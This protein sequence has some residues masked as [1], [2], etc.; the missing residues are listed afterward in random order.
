MINQQ[1]QQKQ[2]CG[3]IVILGRPNVGKSTLLNRLVRQKLSIT[4]RKPQTTRDNIQGIDTEGNYQSIFIDTPG[5]FHRGQLS[6]HYNSEALRALKDVDT[7]LIVLSGLK[8]ESSDKK[9]IETALLAKKNNNQ[10]QLVIV[11]NKI[12][13][14]KD[15]K[16]LLAHIQC[17]FDSYSQFQ[18][19]TISA[20]N[21]KNIDNLRK[22][23]QSL[24]PK[25]A[26]I[27]RA[28]QITDATIKSISG[29]LVREKIVRQLGAELPYATTVIVE[30]FIEN[31]HNIA[32]NAVILVE[33]DSQ[34]AIVIG[35][36]GARLKSIGMAA[37]KDIT[38]MVD[39]KVVLKLW[40]K[41][42]PHWNKIDR[43]KHA[44]SRL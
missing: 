12:D 18:Y 10:L 26:F 27:Y 37:R 36:N 23:I 9:T 43:F 20:K 41:V 17:L 30:K 6:Q 19:V 16:L 40:V 2:F 32:I 15:V 44:N 21:N 22:V 14:I 42:D 8:L 34:K 33:R 31:S 11:V 39:K 38:Q 13:R 1:E 25:R 7:A 29:E 28:T 4:S 3:H 35:K 5:L 24:L